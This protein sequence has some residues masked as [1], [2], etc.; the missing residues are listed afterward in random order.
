MGL[1]YVIL[2]NHN[3]NHVVWEIA[4]LSRDK[5][6]GVEVK[7]MLQGNEPGATD[8]V[9]FDIDNL[10]LQKVKADHFEGWNVAPGEIAFSHSG[11][12]TGA[13]KT[14]IA[15][16]LDAREFQLI[17]STTKK[18]V[19]AKKVTEAK[20]PS[21]TFQLLDFSEVRDP[22]TYFLRAGTHG[23]RT[24]P[25][26]D[27][28]W[29]S[30]IWKAINFFYTERCGVAIPGIHDACHRDWI[31]KHGDKSLIV[32]G[33]W[34][35]A[36]DLS[37]SF[38]NTAETTYAIFTLAERFQARNE[39]PELTNRLIEEA[40]WGLDWVMRTSFG[41]GFRPTFS[42]MDRWTNGIIG[43]FDDMI[44][45]AGN[46]PAGNFLAA[47]A[48][49][50]G[51][52][53]LRQRDPIIS[54][55]SS[56]QAEQ[57]F[58]FA[59]DGMASAETGGPRRGSASELAGHGILAAVELWKTT[60][61]KIYADKAVELSRTVLDSQQREFLPGLTLPLAGLFYSG[62]N[63]QYI[64]RY[65]HLS[66]EGEPVEAL[67]LLCRTFPEHPDWMKW[68]TAVTLYSEYY[69]KPMAGL[70]APYRMLANSV[71]ADDE[72]RKVTARGRGMTPESYKA[73]VLNGV[74]V[75]EHH[76]VRRFPVWFEFRGNHGTVL[77]QTK[78]ISTA[79]HLRGS[80]DM[81]TLS[82]QQLEWVMGKNPFVQSTMWGEG[83]DYAPQYSAMSG[84]LVGS[85]PVGI[86]SHADGDA[87][88]W[89]AE[90]CHNWKE[91]WVFPVARWF[92]LMRDL[93]GPA[94]VEG[95]VKAAERVV[96]IRELKTNRVIRVNVDASS[97]FR[98]MVPEGEYAIAAA[99]E[100]RTL[101]LLPGGAYSLDLRPGRSLDF[102]LSQQIANDGTV[103]LSVIAEGSG[104]HK[105]SVRGG[106]VQFSEPE[107]RIDVRPG[108]PQ[109]LV[110][111]GRLDSINAP[112]V[113]VV[114]PDGDLAQRKEVT[115]VLFTQAR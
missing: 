22:G 94:L 72:Y 3:W 20:S 95:Q 83:Y 107:R 15:S 67:A 39:D 13:V 2:R 49:A 86:Q 52:R 100:R 32:N 12:Q 31:L 1:N 103:S 10:E 47:A 60:G 58:K 73:Q 26:G 36:G 74:K 18:V 40:Q 109:T 115:G 11:Y 25:I 111:K 46:N 80:A 97:K 113:A 48:E 61:K 43:D 75:G 28:I 91:V 41:D 105:L 19:L 108:A 24:F 79:A 76:Y 101:T 62:P 70:S 27:D 88:Y 16:D 112:W 51:S 33:G 50:I 56:N 64:Q 99:G 110:W 96:E 59:I 57:D 78:G 114:Y 89:P 85:L 7:Y 54:L 21:G 4:N 69:Q 53:L 14:A 65:S 106:N 17:D 44:A 102:K 90:N 6:T 87:P 23:T 45:Q 66:H 5:V 38:A 30:S 35:D 93:A 37:Q 98:A 55:Y 104:S 82:Q 92:W 8:T 34:H 81:A 68:Y 77:S 29:K 42:T 63:K 9:T 84:D 71:H